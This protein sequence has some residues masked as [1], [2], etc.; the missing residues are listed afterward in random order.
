MQV[1]QIGSGRPAWQV[2]DRLRAVG[3]GWHPLLLRL[4]EQIVTVDPGYRIDDLK[5]KLSAVRVRISGAAM[6]PEI[7]GLVL[8]AEVRSATICE[9]CGQPG[10]RRRRGDAEF[11]WIKA[12]CDSCHTAWSDHSIMIVN[13][14]VR[15]RPTP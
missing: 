5:E 9:F 1:P 6:P 12:V 8:S 14:V 4:H 3:P 7:R 11:G 2:L 13:G 15:H 10:R